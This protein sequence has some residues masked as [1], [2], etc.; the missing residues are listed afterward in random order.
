[1][2][3]PVLETHQS[4]AVGC[5]ARFKA[6][7]IDGVDSHGEAAKVGTV[8]HR[9]AEGLSTWR[10]DRAA[11]DPTTMAF[12]LLREQALL[13][14]LS[15]A[16][17]A[18]AVSIL[19]TVLAPDSRLSLW[20]RPGRNG[21]AEMRWGLYPHPE[22][23]EL[24]ATDDADPEREFYAAGTIDLLEWTGG[25]AGVTVTD[26]KTTLVM[27]SAED[28]WQSWQG[29]LYAYAVLRLPGF[30][31]AEEV[32]FR[33]A[34][35][36]HGYAVEA[37]FRR[38]DPWER[39]VEERLASIRASRER[40]LASGVWEETLGP[41]CAWCPVMGRCEAQKAAAAQGEEALAGLDLP[42]AARTMLGLEARAKVLRKRVRAAVEKTGDPV[43]LEDPHG[44]VLGFVPTQGWETV[45]SYEQTI[46][47]LRLYGLTDAQFVEHFRFV[48][49]NHWPSR[50]RKVLKQELGADEGTIDSLVIP[51]TK[52]EFTTYV[53]ERVLESARPATIEDLDRL[54]GGL[55]G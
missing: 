34:L 29:R 13:L 53:P 43:P 16:A 55:D 4:D 14:K 39:G 3:H 35:L 5:L 31:R 24:V 50:V 49:P 36:R 45:Q 19:E 27:L 44:T 17:V 37:V 42:T 48:A 32:T 1:M 18:D 25:A 38:G 10:V 6:E 33:L 40:A 28:A 54:L 47:A 7:V 21:V 30:E 12:T 46:D 52:S 9:V 20:A 26:W 2:K 8:L 51:V 11:A 15:P 23:G 41:W 22:S